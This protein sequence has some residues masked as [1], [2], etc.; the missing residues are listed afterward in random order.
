MLKQD[1]ELKLEKFKN[2]HKIRFIIDNIPFNVNYS[3][4]INDKEQEYIYI[5]NQKGEIEYLFIYSAI[6]DIIPL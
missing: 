1:I 6:N 4:I 3:D 2:Y 5:K